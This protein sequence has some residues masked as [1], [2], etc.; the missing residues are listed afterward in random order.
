M[1]RVM[2]C[3]TSNLDFRL[4]LWNEYCFL[5]LGILHGVQDKFPDEVPGAAV[6]KLERK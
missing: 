6:I 3:N 2:T 5:V 1:Q 4:S